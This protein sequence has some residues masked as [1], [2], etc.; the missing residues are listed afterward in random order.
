MFY[1]FFLP[2]RGKED[3]DDD[4]QIWDSTDGFA[5]ADRGSRVR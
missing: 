4:G 2:P 1:S 3:V 5:L